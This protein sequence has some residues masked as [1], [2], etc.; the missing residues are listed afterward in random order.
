MNMDSGYL[1][2]WLRV[3]LRQ[4]HARH[5][6]KGGRD[7]TPHIRHVPEVNPHPPTTRC[8]MD[9]NRP[10]IAASDDVTSGACVHGIDAQEDTP[11]PHP[12]QG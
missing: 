3:G 8:Q 4:R 6:W 9:I 2:P 11:R 7:D 12:R 1:F 5:Q 10:D